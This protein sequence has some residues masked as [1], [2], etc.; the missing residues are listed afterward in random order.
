MVK[1]ASYIVENTQ[2]IPT[3]GLQTTEDVSSGL[4]GKFFL[5]SK[6]QKLN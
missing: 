4:S 2:G 1:L 5:K 6:E 3:S